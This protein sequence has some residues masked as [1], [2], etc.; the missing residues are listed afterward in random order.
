MPRSVI[1]SSK[2]AKSSTK[3]D[4]TSDGFFVGSVEPR[5]QSPGELSAKLET[6]KHFNLVVTNDEEMSKSKTSSRDGPGS[7]DELFG[8]DVVLDVNVSEVQSNT[9]DTSDQMAGRDSEAVNSRTSENNLA[10]QTTASKSSGL[11]EG[12]MNKA[13][14]GFLDTEENESDVIQPPKH[15]RILRSLDD[16]STDDEGDMSQPVFSLRFPTKE[17]SGD[18]EV[19]R[20]RKENA[21]ELRTANPEGRD[22]AFL[23][24]NIP[25]DS[26]SVMTQ[27]E[28]QGILG[29]SILETIASDGETL[30]PSQTP[31]ETELSS[32][33][34][35]TE[36]LEGS[37]TPVSSSSAERSTAKGG[38]ERFTV[39]VDSDDSQPFKR[40][41]TEAAERAAA[42]ALRRQQE[43]TVGRE[44]RR[45]G[46]S[47]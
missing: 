2:N 9:I 47:R 27:S 11:P 36:T 33:K 44:P 17:T 45:A 38:A 42:A 40:K 3:N 4:G 28:S 35:I 21:A 5:A 30:L 8:A 10:G 20:S 39:D 32:H 31:S 15:R 14:A 19:S 24:D 6:S 7:S 25:L 41:R 46:S 23:D 34:L 18:H 16:D 37:I 13:D 26:Q 29:K 1:T 22:E 12:D 43:K